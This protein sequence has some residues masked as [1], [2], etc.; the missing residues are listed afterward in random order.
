MYFLIYLWSTEKCSCMSLKKCCPSWRVGFVE[1]GKQKK[2]LRTRTRTTSNNQ[3]SVNP[4]IIE[5]SR[6]SV[7]SGLSP[8][9]S[10]LLGRILWTIWA[11]AQLQGYVKGVCACTHFVQWLSITKISN[12]CRG[13]I[14]YLCHISQ[15]LSVQWTLSLSLPNNTALIMTPHR[16]LVSTRLKKKLV[17]KNVQIFEHLDLIFSRWRGYINNSEKWK[18]Q[19]VS[20]INNEIADTACLSIL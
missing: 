10:F 5:N 4:L 9:Q 20:G 15:A 19:S 7:Q 2:K 16:G 12:L 3:A 17:K 6:F 11:Q 14:T 18:E 8:P 1:A 13:E